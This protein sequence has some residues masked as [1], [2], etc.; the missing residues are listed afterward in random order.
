VAK[1]NLCVM[2]EV[3]GTEIDFN[4]EQYIV[5]VGSIRV[6]FDPDSKANNESGQRSRRI[7][8]E[9]ARQN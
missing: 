8:T 6:S 1:E 3:M 9:E 4:D 7:S 2:T 5:I